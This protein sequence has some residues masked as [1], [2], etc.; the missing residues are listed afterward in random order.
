MLIYPP[1][2]N[3]SPEGQQGL[4]SSRE[5]K[6]GRAGSMSIHWGEL[7]FRAY[8]NNTTSPMGAGKGA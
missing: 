3:Q 8:T 7:K 2:M 6:I 4:L 5:A 1:S